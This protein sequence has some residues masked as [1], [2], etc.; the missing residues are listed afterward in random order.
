MILDAPESRGL[1]LIAVGISFDYK[2]VSLPYGY[3]KHSQKYESVENEREVVAVGVEDPAGSPDNEGDKRDPDIVAGQQ[4]RE[5][6]V[7]FGG[8]GSHI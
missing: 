4:I 2:A 3:E 1:V 6:L 5:I 8:I 7:L